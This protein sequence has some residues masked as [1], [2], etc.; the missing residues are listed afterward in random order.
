M[1]MEDYYVPATGKTHRIVAKSSCPKGPS[2]I[3]ISQHSLGVLLLKK[4]LTF[5]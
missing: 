2:K 4:E 1:A 3:V 5:L